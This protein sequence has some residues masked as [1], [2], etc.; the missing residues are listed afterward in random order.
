MPVEAVISKFSEQVRIRSI[1]QLIKG[2][3][4]VLQNLMKYFNG[5]AISKQLTFVT[6]GWVFSCYTSLKRD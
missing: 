5:S 2:I 1:S 3:S 4:R 6:N